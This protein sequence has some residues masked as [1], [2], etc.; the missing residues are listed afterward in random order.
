VTI[1]QFA[2]SPESLSVPAGTTVTW[3]NQDL[4][5]PH[6]LKFSDGASGVLKKGASYSRTFSSAGVYAYNC[7]VH[8]YM[9]GKVTVQ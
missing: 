3:T 4:D 1:V 7:G 5:T 2:F 8:P 6:S 9:T